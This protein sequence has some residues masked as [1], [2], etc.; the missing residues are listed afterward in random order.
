MVC[1]EDLLLGKGKSYQESLN[2]VT[3]NPSNAEAK[4]LFK[5]PYCARCMKSKQHIEDHIRIH[6]GE[7]PY[8]CHK[9][10]YASNQGIN[11]R[12]HL[13][14]YKNPPVECEHCDLKFCSM[15]ALQNH[16]KEEHLAQGTSLDKVIPEGIINESEISLGEAPNLPFEDMDVEMDEDFV[17]DSCLF[18]ITPEIK[19]D[20]VYSM[21]EPKRVMK[22]KPRRPTTK[23]LEVNRVSLKKKNSFKVNDFRCMYCNKTHLNRSHM[24]EHV[25]IHTGERPY[26]CAYC[27]YASIT[28]SALRTHNKSSTGSCLKCPQCDFTSCTVPILQ[29]HKNNTH[30]TN[31]TSK[32]PLKT[33]VIRFHKYK[34]IKKPIKLENKSTKKE[35]NLF[36]CDR[37]SYTTDSQL[38]I[39]VHF[40]HRK[41]KPINSCS[42]CS[43]SACF[44][45]GLAKHRKLMHGGSVNKSI[46]KKKQKIPQKNAM[47]KEDS[48]VP[49]DVENQPM[50]GCA[51]CPFFSLDKTEVTK[52]LVFHNGPKPYSCIFCARRFTTRINAEVHERIHTG[53]QPFQCSHCGKSFSQKCN[54]HTHL[55]NR[56]GIQIDGRKFTRMP[57]LKVEPGCVVRRNTLDAAA[58]VSRK[59]RA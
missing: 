2:K 52:H 53:L 16:V 1:F 58:K 7:K 57:K 35:K 39:D 48:P 31:G 13:Q 11:L 9:C 32:A 4:P 5:C 29:R 51:Y 50:Y 30:V 59:Y 47:E 45:I 3:M 17:K 20:S 26:K 49:S 43:Y 6:T 41:N 21:E 28:A 10:C 44:P 54:L 36:H 56:H 27:S 25:R 34:R 46:L 42:D 40:H 19:I 15:K 38:N 22:V 8:Q 23:K 18:E 24:E 12:M 14:K 55:I 33:P 37:C